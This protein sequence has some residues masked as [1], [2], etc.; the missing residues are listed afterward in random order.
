MN[1]HFGWMT[2]SETQNLLPVTIVILLMVISTVGMF[3]F[4]RYK[5]WI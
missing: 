2:V 1:V 4:F 5:K 3:Q